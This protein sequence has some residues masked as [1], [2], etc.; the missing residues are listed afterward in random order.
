[1]DYCKEQNLNSEIDCFH[2]KSKTLGF[3]ENQAKGSGMALVAILVSDLADT[4]NIGKNM[5]AAQVT[6]TAMLIVNDYPTLK[7]DDVAFCF[8]K[9]KK[10]L[11][12]KVY[13]RL[14]SAIIFGWIE[15]FLADKDEQVEYYWQ[16]QQN[17]VKTD[18]T[19]LLL[20]TPPAVDDKVAISYIRKIK[21]KVIEIQINNNKAKRIIDPK[22]IQEN[23]LYEIHQQF[24]QKF[25]ELYEIEI[26]GMTREPRGM[27]FITCCGRKLDVGE[28]VQ[29][30]HTQLMM[31]AEKIEARW[32]FL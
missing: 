25:N 13:D 24:I 22:P 9:A 10:G 5:S 20:P 16:H 2:S 4:F 6:D 17:V 14:D 18:N 26:F 21:Q 19:Q 30:K 31:L 28:Y 1:M 7:I 23:L 15:M 32:N 3:L 11:Y 12:G 8:T 29:R 27:R